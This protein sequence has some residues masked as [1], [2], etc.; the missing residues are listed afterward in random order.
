LKFADFKQKL[1]GF[2][3]QKRADRNKLGQA[4]QSR[5]AQQRAP[6]DAEKNKISA[7]RPSPPVSA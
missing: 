6:G 7:D 4:G 3:K 1:N 5:P 2:S